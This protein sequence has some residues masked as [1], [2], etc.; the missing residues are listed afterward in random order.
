[1]ADGSLEVYCVD[2]GFVEH[3]MPEHVQL[4]K[5]EFLA[6]PAQ[7]LHLNMTTDKPDED[8]SS[9]QSL[10]PGTTVMATIIEADSSNRR[11][12]VKFSMR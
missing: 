8:L 10:L 7:G 5:Q 6:L 12:S 1:M 2:Y 11:A 3:V 9:F 4:L